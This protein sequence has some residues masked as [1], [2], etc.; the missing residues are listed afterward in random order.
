MTR[1]W[2]RLLTT[3]I[4]GILIIAAGAWCVEIGRWLGLHIP[5]TPVRGQMWATEPLPPR[6]FHTI[7]SAESAMDWHHA[8][9]NDHETPPHLTHQGSVRRTRHLYGR[10]TRDGEIIFGGDR[11]LVGYNTAPDPAGIEVNHTHA[12][13]VLPV[14]TTLS[15]ARTWAGLMPSPLT[16]RRYRPDSAAPQSFHREW[17]GLLRLWARSYGGQI[18]GRRSAHGPAAPCAGCRRPGALRQHD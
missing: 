13:E 17:P 4:A 18:A 12:A 11:Q 14:L 6:L 1:M 2:S 3:F 15:I 8:P 10:Q 7:S 16:A 9:G 5:I